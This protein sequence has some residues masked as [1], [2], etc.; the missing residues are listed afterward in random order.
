MDIEKLQTHRRFLVTT[1]GVASPTTALL[2][3]SRQLAEKVRIVLGEGSF[4]CS[5]LTVPNADPGILSWL[6]VVGLKRT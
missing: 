2:A 4:P 1:N 5:L 3:E 6:G